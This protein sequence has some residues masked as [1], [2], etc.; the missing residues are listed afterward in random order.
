MENVSVELI[1]SVVVGCVTGV[2]GWVRSRQDASIA[3]AS[4]N[5]LSKAILIEIRNEN[6]EGISS[7][8]VIEEFTSRAR[9]FTE[10]EVLNKALLAM[11]ASEIL[12]NLEQIKVRQGDST[13]W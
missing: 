6:T 1:V 5:A 9:G 10:S 3:H 7:T 11:P 8:K 12:W 2:W 4:K 13:L